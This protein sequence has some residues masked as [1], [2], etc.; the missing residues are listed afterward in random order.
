[1]IIG[2]SGH[3]RHG[4]DTIADII[5]KHYGFKKHALADVMK[6][7]CR[8]IFGWTDAHLYGDL[9]DIIDQRYG[10]SPRHALQTLGT[11]WGQFE[12]SK[13]DSFAETTG[14]KLWVNSLLSRVSNDTVISDVRFPHEAEAIKEKGGIIIMVR[15]T[16]Y[17]WDHSHESELAVEDIKPDYVI[18][19]CAGLN[20]LERDVL[21][22]MRTILANR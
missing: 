21:D 10:I 20:E 19:N 22:E 13:Y 6:E 9:K 14:R 1:M 15:R 4:K 8:V 3:A 17:P 16:C 5:V 18:R 11:Q 12:L 7:A 2:I